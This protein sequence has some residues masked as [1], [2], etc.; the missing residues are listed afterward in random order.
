MPEH[1]NLSLIKKVYESFA[2]GDYPS[3]LKELFREDV[4]WHLPGNGPLSAEHRGREAVFAA[5]RQF[6]QLSRGSIRIEVHD[7]LANEEHAVALLRATATRQGKQYDSREVDIY[8]IRDGKVTEMWSLSE[9]PRVTD[10]F[11]S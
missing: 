4:V 3:K 6:E 5:M 9:D 10:E 2:T 11:W 1:P 7:I 8:H